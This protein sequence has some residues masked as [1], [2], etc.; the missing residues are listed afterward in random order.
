[1]GVAFFA[2]FAALMGA[3]CY[4]PREKFT[5]DMGVGEDRYKIMRNEGVAPARSNKVQP[6]QRGE[7]S[8]EGDRLLSV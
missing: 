3:A 1:M 7:S 2:L 4:S 5:F 8:R 6:L